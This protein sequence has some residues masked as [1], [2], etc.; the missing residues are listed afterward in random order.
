MNTNSSVAHSQFL[1]LT[2]SL[3]VSGVFTLPWMLRLAINDDLYAETTIR[4][5]VS[6]TLS[7]V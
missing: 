2:K 4:E 3:R 6:H 1:A 7:R 5:N